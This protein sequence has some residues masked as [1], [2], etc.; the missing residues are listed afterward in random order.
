MIRRAPKPRPRPAESLQE[1]FAAKYR[2]LGDETERYPGI[3]GCHEWTA[4]NDG[5]YGQIRVNGRWKKAHIVSWELSGGRPLEPGEILLHQCDHM[6]CVRF[7]HLRPGTH[8]ENHDDAV[9]K[10]RKYS[11]PPK[12]EPEL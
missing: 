10:G 5:R 4:S 6:R 8:Q 9:T 7:S 12:E 2:V 11:F 3:G 1:R